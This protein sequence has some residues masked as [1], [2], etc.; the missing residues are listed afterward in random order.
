MARERHDRLVHVRRPL[1]RREPEHIDDRNVRL[2]R[3]IQL[4]PEKREFAARP[5]DHVGLRGDLRYYRDVNG[6]VVNN[7][8][9]GKFHFWRMS[10]GVVLR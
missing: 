4:R 10:A 7:I 6:D 3:R 1:P 8:D 5:D 2:I 9:L